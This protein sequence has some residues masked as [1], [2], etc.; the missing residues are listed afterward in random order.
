MIIRL[1]FIVITTL[2]SNS[3]LASSL[4]ETT[5]Q[6]SLP[7]SD[8]ILKPIISDELPAYSPPSSSVGNAES[9][10]NSDGEYRTF[11]LGKEPPVTEWTL[12]PGLHSNVDKATLITCKTAAKLAL[13]HLVV[14]GCQKGV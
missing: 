10:S 14:R 11:E 8:P 12:F 7:D 13:Q 5:W 2:L 9:Q 6:L 3:L 4:T 1:I